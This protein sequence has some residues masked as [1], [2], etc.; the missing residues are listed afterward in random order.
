MNKYLQTMG[1]CTYLKIKKYCFWHATKTACPLSNDHFL[2]TTILQLFP[3]P[4]VLL[5][6]NPAPPKLIQTTLS[7]GLLMFS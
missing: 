2:P 7:P 5:L 4:P 6:A 1:A 3:Q